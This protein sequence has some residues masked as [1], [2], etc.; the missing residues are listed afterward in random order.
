MDD[1]V[2]ELFE[3]FGQSH[4]ELKSVGILTC[5]DPLLAVLSG[6]RELE[7]PLAGKITLNRLELIGRSTRYHKITY[8]AEAIDRLLTDLFVESHASPPVEIV[9]DLNATDIPI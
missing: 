5:Q 9:L 4:G 6:K 8:S 1:G 2:A 7:E 3:S